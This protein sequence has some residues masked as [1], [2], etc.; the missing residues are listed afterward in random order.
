MRITNRLPTTGI[1]VVVGALCFVAARPTPTAAYCQG[2]FEAPQSNYTWYTCYDSAGGGTIT[3]VAGRRPSDGKAFIDVSCE[4]SDCHGYAW[5]QGFDA[6]WNG[7][8]YVETH[9]GEVS[10]VCPQSLA[11]YA[12]LIQAE[13]Q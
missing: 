3:A 13:P 5:V 12:F 6:D 4:N 11:D 2:T 9:G 8:C 7:I 1:A 10:E